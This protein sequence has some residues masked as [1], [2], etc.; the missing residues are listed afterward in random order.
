MESDRAKDC[1]QINLKSNKVGLIVWWSFINFSNYINLNHYNINENANDQ[2]F[3]NL[4]GLRQRVIQ[5]VWL[6]INIFYFYH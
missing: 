3:L 1:Q 2:N 5:H 4:I 6:Y